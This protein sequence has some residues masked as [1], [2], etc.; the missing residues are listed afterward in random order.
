MI[1]V[2]YH[3]F[4]ASI[5]DVCGKDNAAVLHSNQQL[6]RR[7]WLRAHL[8]S[9]GRGN[10]VLTGDTAN[11]LTVMNQETGVFEGRVPSGESTSV[12]TFKF[13]DTTSFIIGNLHVI[14]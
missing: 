14:R 5:K 12:N 11:L 2:I 3:F 4:I 9:E 10:D 6:Y 1:N 7:W 13:P 8:S